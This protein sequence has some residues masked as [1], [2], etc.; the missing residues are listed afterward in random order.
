MVGNGKGGLG[1]SLV[2]RVRLSSI[3]C[4]IYTCVYLR[5]QEPVFEFR[6]SDGPVRNP[7]LLHLIHF[8]V[9]LSLILEDGIPA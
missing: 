3:V 9:R 2:F 6:Q 8:R 7:I 5:L 4:A 1:A